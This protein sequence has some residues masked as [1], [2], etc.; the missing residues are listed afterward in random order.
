MTATT[1]DVQRPDGA[2]AIAAHLRVPVWNALAERADLLRRSLPPRPE[3]AY[4]R[5][6][7]LRALDAEQA[8]RAAL[9]DRLEALRDHVAGRPALGYAPA[10]ALPEEAL[11]EVDGFTTRSTALI[12]AEYRA[13]QAS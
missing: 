2:E 10:D 9:L 13:W 7:W 11:E 1:T 6:V 3:T 12:I 8:R 4:G 5:Y